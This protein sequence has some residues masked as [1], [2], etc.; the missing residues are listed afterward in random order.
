[1]GRR[2]QELTLTG[3]PDWSKQRLQIGVDTGRRCR[4]HSQQN[5]EG[6]RVGRLITFAMLVSFVAQQFACCCV[7][8]CASVCHRDHSPQVICETVDSGHSDCGHHQHDASETGETADRDHEERPVDGHQHHVCVGT[9]L[10]Y[11]TAER[12]DVSRLVVIQG[13]DLCWSEDFVG[14]GTRIDATTDRDRLGD[15]ALRSAGLERSVLCVYRI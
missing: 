10:F 9:H 11:L 8:A 4:T 6:I 12:F 2:I 14:L 1:M 13:F 5:L 3:S 15:V 7:G